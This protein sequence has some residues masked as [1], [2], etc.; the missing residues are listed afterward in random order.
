MGRV[1][2]CRGG[3]WPPRVDG[4]SGVMLGCEGEI[5]GS[6]GTDRGHE[7]PDYAPLPTDANC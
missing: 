4:G 3:D 7:L 2:G 1:V 5:D 6:D